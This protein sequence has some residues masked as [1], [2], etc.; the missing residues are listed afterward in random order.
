MLIFAGALLAYREKNSKC[1]AGLSVGSDYGGFVPQDISSKPTLWTSGLDEFYVR[2]EAFGN[3][4]VLE[5]ILTKWKNRYGTF[6][7]PALG[8]SDGPQVPFKDGTI[9]IAIF[10]QMHCLTTLLEDFGR[11]AA[12]TRPEQLPSYADGPPGYWGKHKAHCFNQVRQAL[13]CLSDSTAEGH[14]ELL[15]PERHSH[16]IADTGVTHVCNDFQA[17]LAWKNGHIAGGGGGGY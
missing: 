7:V 15:D 4:S 6:Y 16:S 14:N 12:G 1:L 8:Y 13:E 11:L 5:E 10:H 2:G 9:A 3:T 17:L